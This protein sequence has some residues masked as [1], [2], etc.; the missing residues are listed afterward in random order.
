[1]SKISTIFGS[2]PKAFA[3]PMIE[4]DHPEIDTFDLLD[5][6]GIKHYQ[7]LIV[8]LQW[9]VPLGGFDVHLG[10]ATVSTYRCAPCQG[11]LKQLKLMFDY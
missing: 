9:L 2:K 4:K 5:G 10:V 11:H 6:L 7:S 8:G 1:V 3:T